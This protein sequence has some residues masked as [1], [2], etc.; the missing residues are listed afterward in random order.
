MGM[1][2]EAS[3]SSKIHFWGC[4]SLLYYLFMLS[5]ELADKTTHSK[6]VRAKIVRHLI[7]TSLLLGGGVASLLSLTTY[8]Q[9]DSI[10]SGLTTSSAVRSAS[11]TIF[12][13]VLV[14]QVF[15][16]LAYPVNGIIMGGLDWVFTMVGAFRRFLPSYLSQ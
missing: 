9:R 11:A 4:N 13:A 1:P 6:S 10:L 14:T 16:G 15:K 12:P 7:S 5:R 2:H 8:L 3:S